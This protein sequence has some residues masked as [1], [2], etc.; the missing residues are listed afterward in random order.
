MKALLIDDHPLVNIGITSWL[1]E[2]GHFSAFE[3]AQTLAEAKRFIEDAME[4]GRSLPSIVV[5]DVQL[6]NENGLDFIRFL[7][8][9]RETKS[10]PVLVCSILETLSS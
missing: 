1:A 6:G 9:S 10:I 5:L 3:Q 8:G 7:K 2:T 4:A